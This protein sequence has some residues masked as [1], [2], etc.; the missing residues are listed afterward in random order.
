MSLLKVTEM[1][2]KLLHRMLKLSFSDHEFVGVRLG[3]AVA[4][5]E[6]AGGLIVR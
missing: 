1:S 2:A 6:G 5:H 3:E 4:I